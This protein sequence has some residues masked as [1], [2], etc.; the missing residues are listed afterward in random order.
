ML[1]RALLKYK[2]GR[3]TTQRPKRKEL[4]MNYISTITTDGKTFAEYQAACNEERLE[5]EAKAEIPKAAVKPA[6][7]RHWCQSNGELDYDC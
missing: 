5:N 6:T 1:A 2:A 3:S 7:R 4:T